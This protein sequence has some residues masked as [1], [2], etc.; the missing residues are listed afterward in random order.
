[1]GWDW[2]V[3]FDIPEM[4]FVELHPGLLFLIIPPLFW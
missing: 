3:T 1:M 4:Y 2:G